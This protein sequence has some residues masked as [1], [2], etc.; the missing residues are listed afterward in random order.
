MRATSAANPG[1]SRGFL[2]NILAALLR[3]PGR[4]KS[5]SLRT[6]FPRNFALAIAFN[7]SSNTRSVLH[8]TPRKSSGTILRIPSK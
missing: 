8:G 4:S 6:D 3:S 1:A 7:V 5:K 2:F